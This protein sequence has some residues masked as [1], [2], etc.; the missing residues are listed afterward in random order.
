ME[1]LIKFYDEPREVYSFNTKTEAIRYIRYRQADIESVNHEAVFVWV[2]F[3]K[4][5]LRFMTDTEL[6]RL[7]D[8][9]CEYTKRGMITTK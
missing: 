4:G 1:C 6:S 5:K 9:F 3:G 7:L 2:P 8:K